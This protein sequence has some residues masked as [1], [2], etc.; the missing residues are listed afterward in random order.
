MNVKSSD[1]PIDPVGSS[2]AN[3]QVLATKMLIRDLSIERPDVVSYLQTIVPEKQEIALVHAIEVGITEIVARR[4][5]A[6]P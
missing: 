4:E 3:V 5:R 2:S 6:R 1:E